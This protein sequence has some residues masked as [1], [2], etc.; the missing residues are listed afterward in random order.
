MSLENSIKDVITKKLEDG[1][2]EKL[3][4]EQLENGIKNALKD[5]LGSYGDVTKVIEKQVKSVMIPYLE[6]YDYSEYITKLDSVLVDVL[7]SSALE[8]KKMLENFKDLMIPEEM[9]TIKVTDLFERWKKYVEHNVETDDLEVCY[10]D[11]PPSFEYVD[12]RFE[13]EFNEERSW[14]S[15]KHAVLVFECEHDKKMNFEIRIHTW[16]EFDKGK[17]TIERNSIHDINSLR[18]LDEFS[19]LLMKLNQN[20]TKLILDSDSEG[21]EI[22]PDKEPEASFS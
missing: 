20:G 8:N 16:P 17:W 21:D 14:S 6:N 15:V 5:L 12:V 2:I 4:A 3:I 1:T 11:G 7:K 19:I 13:V 22:K 9:E 18:Y 10:E